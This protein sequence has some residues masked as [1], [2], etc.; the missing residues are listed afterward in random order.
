MLKKKA[1]EAP[2]ID[3]TTKPLSELVTDAFDIINNFLES[4]SDSVKEGG[5]GYLETINPELYKKLQPIL[6]EIARRSKEKRLDMRSYLFGAVD[7]QAEGKAKQLYEMAA[8]KHELRQRKSIT[9][10]RQKF[11]RKERGHRTAQS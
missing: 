10:K 1:E 7:A 3:L 4:A 11:R 5:T 2:A 6:A 9:K 8:K